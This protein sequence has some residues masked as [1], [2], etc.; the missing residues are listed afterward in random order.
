M[1][2]LFRFVTFILLGLFLFLSLASTPVSARDSFRIN[3]R[4]DTEEENVGLELDYDISY[5][6]SLSVGLGLTVLDAGSRGTAC[7]G[8]RY[9][10]YGDGSRFYL[11]LRG[12]T[13]FYDDSFRFRV[14]VGFG[15]TTYISGNRGAL[16]LELLIGSMGGVLEIK[17]SIGI[18]IGINR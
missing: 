8:L 12:L 13:R 18:S 11:K 3:A 7:L 4:L 16:E 14:G 9:Y 6:L 17:P 10:L 1:S 15:Y 5:R 2:R